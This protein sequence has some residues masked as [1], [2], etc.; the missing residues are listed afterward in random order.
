VPAGETE[1]DLEGELEAVEENEVEVGSP[2]IPR[3]SLRQKHVPARLNDCE[4]TFDGAVNYEGD[5]VHFALLVESE[6]V[7][8]EEAMKN[9][10]WLEAMKEEIIS[11]EKNLTS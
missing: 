7:T 4:I 2:E 6:P 10:E 5:I 3:R 11:I 1:L 8:L 9:A